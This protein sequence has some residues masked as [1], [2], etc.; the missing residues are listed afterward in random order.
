[1]TGFST[2]SPKLDPR[3]VHFRVPGPHRGLSLFLR[4]LAPNREA[5]SPPKPVL[6]VHGGTFPSAL[7]I[8]HRFDGRSWR[9]EL[10][11]AGFHT[12]GLDF[13]GFG[14]SD[15]Y[16]E[17]AGPA[18]AI[19]PLG[20]AADCSRQLENAVRFI[21]DYHRSPRI[22]YRLPV[23]S[24]CGRVNRAAYHVWG[25][26]CRHTSFAANRGRP[27]CGAWRDARAGASVSGF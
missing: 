8:A 14:D 24:R 19:P 21:A 2:D 20:R 18:E 7:S 9:D 27:S 25:G 6:Y 5:I 4:Y 1:M 10:C 23:I 17:M 26:R 15:P 22:S 16:P 3:E 11:H 13:H 12:W